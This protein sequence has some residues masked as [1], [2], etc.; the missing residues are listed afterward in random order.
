VRFYPGR[1]DSGPKIA[2][3]NKLVQRPPCPVRRH[4]CP[5]AHPR[6]PSIS[7]SRRKH[8]LFR[9]DSSQSSSEL[10]SERRLR[11]VV[12]KA[13]CIFPS[14]KRR[15]RNRARSASQTAFFN[16]HPSPLERCQDAG[17]VPEKA[18]AAQ[19]A[20]FSPE[21]TF[22]ESELMLLIPPTPLGI[23]EG[24]RSR[25]A[26]SVKEARTRSG[27]SSRGKSRVFRRDSPESCREEL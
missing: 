10:R 3:L 2:Q 24:S 23:Q 16:N 6:Y 11:L 26:S 1:L 5:L 25:P 20:R 19:R 4:R 15:S 9:D 14:V 8:L 22:S 27:F 13:R 7:S 17:G 12:L 21:D 18:A